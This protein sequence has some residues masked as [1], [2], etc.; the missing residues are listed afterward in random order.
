MRIKRLVGGWLALSIVISALPARA[1]SG[2]GLEPTASTAAPSTFRASLDRAAASVALVPEGPKG[3]A[4]GRA[5]RARKRSSEFAAE[6]AGGQVIQGGGGGGRGV[7]TLIMT[8]VGTAAGVGATVY[9][10]KQL[11]RVEGA[12]Q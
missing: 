2:S 8:L 6:E 11:K 4:S 5:L 10:L 3:L 9:M 7:A 12:A 1:E